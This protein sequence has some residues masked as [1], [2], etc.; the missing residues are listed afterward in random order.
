MGKARG[1]S[2]P[3]VRDGRS[4]GA[5]PSSSLLAAKAVGRVD[6][7]SAAGWGSWAQRAPCIPASSRRPEPTQRGRPSAAGLPL[8]HA[9]L[10]GHPRLTFRRAVSRP[11]RRYPREGAGMTVE[12]RALHGGRAPSAGSHGAKSSS[13]FKQRQRKAR[14]A[15]QP[16]FY[17]YF[18]RSPGAPRAAACSSVAEAALRPRAARSPLRGRSL[19]GFWSSPPPKRRLRPKPIPRL[20]ALDGAAPS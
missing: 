2:R 3:R 16:W 19:C 5:K 14:S 20:K 18:G 7:R 15:G 11:S 10:R 9:R 4:G 1:L 6:A 13:L 8:R 12:G 17:A